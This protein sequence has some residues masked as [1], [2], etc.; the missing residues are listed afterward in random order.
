MVNEHKNLGVRRVK[1]NLRP[2]VCIP[3]VHMQRQHAPSW[4]LSNTWTR[5]FSGELL[6]CLQ[7]WSCSYP[8]GSQVA[9]GLDTKYTIAR[10]RK[11]TILLIVH[12]GQKR[13]LDT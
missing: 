8:L 1:Y 3:V 5:R 13:R 9:I 6:G 4:R 10:L 11:G 12:H 2:D 7:K